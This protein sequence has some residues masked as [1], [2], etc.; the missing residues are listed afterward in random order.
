MSENNE[1]EFDRDE[2]G[3]TPYLI[4]LGK[5]VY[6]HDPGDAADEFIRLT[7]IEGLATQNFRAWDLVDDEQF[8]V[9]PQGWV[10][11]EEPDDE[12]MTPE[13]YASAIAT[14]LENVKEGE[15]TYVPSPAIVDVELPEPEEPPQ[16]DAAPVTGRCIRCKEENVLN[17]DGHCPEC[18]ADL[19]GVTA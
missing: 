2:E 4:Q 19:K 13:E 12:E 15:L 14:L 10:E 6:G 1:T 8:I 9:T 18:V 11:A 3:R 5:V 7:A 17:E 16:E